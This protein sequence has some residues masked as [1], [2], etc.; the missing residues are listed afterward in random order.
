VAQ[1]VN[2]ITLFGILAADAILFSSSIQDTERKLRLDNQELHKE[3]GT[4]TYEAVRPV[5]HREVYQSEINEIHYVSE[6]DPV[7]HIT[8]TAGNNG[9][10]RC[11]VEPVFR[12]S[13][14]QIN[15]HSDYHN[16]ARDHKQYPFIVEHAESRTV[17]L[18]VCG[19]Q[20]VLYYWLGVDRG[21]KFDGKPFGQLIE[22]DSESYDHGIRQIFHPCALFDL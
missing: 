6:C 18:H 4:D 10:N 19:M 12:I 2:S 17:V 8:D 20:N 13:E 5:E 7:D 9:G 16:G 15:Q 1:T 14:V 11:G 21:E 22:Y 3:A